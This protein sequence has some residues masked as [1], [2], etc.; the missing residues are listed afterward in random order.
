[1]SEHEFTSANFDAEV[2]KSDLP[3]LVDFW[4]EWCGP[5]RMI[6]PFV[7]EVARDYSGRARVGSVNVDNEGDLANAWDVASIPTLIVFKGGVIVAKRIGAVPKKD[8]E[9]LLKDFV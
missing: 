7:A 4:A 1:M 2:L 3:V 6:A 5:C 8:I 9:A